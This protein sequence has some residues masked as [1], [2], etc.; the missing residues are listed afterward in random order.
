MIGIAV[1]VKIWTIKISPYLSH[2]MN[3]LEKKHNAR[4]AVFW[5]PYVQKFGLKSD[6]KVAV[7]IKTTGPK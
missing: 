5:S 3:S 7:P 6:Q 4:D 1:S 2:M